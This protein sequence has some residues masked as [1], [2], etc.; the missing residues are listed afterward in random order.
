MAGNELMEQVHGVLL[1]TFLRMF[2]NFDVDN[3]SS[4]QF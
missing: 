3:S 2:L 1:M 4:F